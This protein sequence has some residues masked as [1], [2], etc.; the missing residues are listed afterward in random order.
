MKG[1]AGAIL[2]CA[3]RACGDLRIAGVHVVLII[4]EEST[5]M[6]AAT[7]GAEVSHR[8][9]YQPSQNSS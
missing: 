7:T 6:D 2:E 8:A 1:A 9:V 3:A 5:R 4:R